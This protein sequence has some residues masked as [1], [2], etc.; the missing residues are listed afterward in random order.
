M[1]AIQFFLKQHA[2]LHSAAVGEAEGSSLEDLVLGE[3]NEEQIRLRPREGLNSLA[4]LIWHIARTEDVM[5]NVV[6]AGRPQVFDVEHWPNRLKVSRRDIGT[7]MDSDEVSELSAKVDI[8]ALRA[9]RLSVGR[10]TQE[11]VRTLRSEELDEVV[12]ESHLQKAVADGAFGPRAG[13]VVE[14]VWRGKTKGFLLGRNS[15][16]HNALHLGEA[17]SVRSQAGLGLSL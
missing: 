5:I 4:W 8:P 1:D 16:V 3:L 12:S 14:R 17:L 2:R 15:I 13:W 11:V 9:Y 7:G 6:I 10:K